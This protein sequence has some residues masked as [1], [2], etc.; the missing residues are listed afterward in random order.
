L[1][2]ALSFFQELGLSPSLWILSILGVISL[3]V[4]KKV[5]EL[6]NFYG[7]NCQ[8]G[9][10]YIHSLGADPEVLNLLTGDVQ[11]KCLPNLIVVPFGSDMVMMTIEHLF[12]ERSLVLCVFW[13]HE[14]EVDEEEED[15]IQ[16]ELADDSADFFVVEPAQSK[17]D[18]EEGATLDGMIAGRLHHCSVPVG[19]R[20]LFVD[21]KV[22]LQLDDGSRSVA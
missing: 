4:R 13:E 5:G 11:L 15:G 3:K 21:T 7:R 8:Q 14:G 9:Q 22:E 20:I 2:S 6:L 12:C 16:G 19:A 1:H 10:Q 18:R 17:D